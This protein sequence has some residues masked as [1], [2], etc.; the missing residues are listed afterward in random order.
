MK[1]YISFLASLVVTFV[2]LSYMWVNAAHADTG[3]R[4]V[5]ATVTMC[6]GAGYQLPAA[7]RGTVR[8]L[9][10]VS[11]HRVNH[12]RGASDLGAP[13]ARVGTTVVVARLGARTGA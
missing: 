10:R 12:V 3:C 7:P 5:G 6:D 13:T 11:A 1:T 4:K 2:I 9:P 8:R